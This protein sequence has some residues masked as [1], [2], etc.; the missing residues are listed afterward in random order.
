[1]HSRR[2]TG[3]SRFWRTLLSAE[4]HVVTVQENEAMDMQQLAEVLRPRLEAAAGG[5]LEAHRR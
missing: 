4:G 5:S 1:M 2:Q 3:R